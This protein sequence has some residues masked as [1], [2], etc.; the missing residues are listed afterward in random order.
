LLVVDVTRRMTLP[1]IRELRIFLENNNEASLENF[2]RDLVNKLAEY[3]NDRVADITD[4]N[5]I[6]NGIWSKINRLERKRTLTKDEAQ[7]LSQL[8]ERAQDIDAQRQRDPALVAHEH[9]LAILWALPSTIPDEFDDD[10]LEEV[11]SALKGDDEGRGHS[12]QEQ[13]ELL[14]TPQKSGRGRPP[15][16]RDLAIEKIVADFKSGKMTV[17]ELQA[18]PPKAVVSRYGLRHWSTAVEARRRAIKKWNEMSATGQP[19][20]EA[21]E[22]LTKSNVHLLQPKTDDNSAA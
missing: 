2:H 5:K 12:S 16:K 7:L 20:T 17:A 11:V 6:L 10:L 8:H 9:V 1:A 15:D 3:L 14:P 18:L 22:N 13:L 4:H 21:A 19:H